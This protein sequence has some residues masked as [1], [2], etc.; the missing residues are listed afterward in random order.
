MNM[1][2]SDMLP[3][4]VMLLIVFSRRVWG[5]KPTAEELAN[6]VKTEPSS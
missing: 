2:E 4:E 3:Q 1:R 6:P 5:R